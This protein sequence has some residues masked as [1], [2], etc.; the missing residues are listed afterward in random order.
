MLIAV[1][2]AAL[3]LTAKP[4]QCRTTAK[5][6]FVG[7]TIFAVL[8]PAM[9]SFET[10]MK[11]VQTVGASVTLVLREASVNNLPIASPVFAQT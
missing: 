10:A 6:V 2:R 9:T 4:V 1:D 8:P 5:A 3:V 11:R 7:P